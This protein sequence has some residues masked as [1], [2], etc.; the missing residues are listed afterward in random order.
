MTMW[1]EYGQYQRIDDVDRWVCDQCGNDFPLD[2]NTDILPH[3][4]E[5]HN[6]ELCDGG[7]GTKG[8]HEVVYCIK[9]NERL[10]PCDECP[11]PISY[12]T[13]ENTDTGDWICE[14]CY[15]TEITK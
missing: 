6:V 13:K 4:E 5:Q 10:D 9:C 7:C 1:E 12:S 11:N 8:G 2:L 3:L 15:E 14:V